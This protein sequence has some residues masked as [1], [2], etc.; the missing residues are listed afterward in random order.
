MSGSSGSQNS[1]VTNKTDV[2]SWLQ[3]A[4][5]SNLGFA[6]DVAAK[7]YEQ[8][9]G[10]QVASI[11]PDQ[12][13][14]YDWVRKNLGAGSNAIGQAAQQITGSNL[15]TT[16]QSL[17]NPYLGA[18]E[19]PALAALAKQGA[20]SQNDLASKAAGA[21]AFG[22]TR[23]G[24]E[25]GVLG[26]ETAAKAGELSAN[27]RSQGWDKAVSTALT[28]AG[29][30]ASLATQQQTAGLA[31]ASA[32]STAGYQQQQNEQA[33]LS[34]ALEDWQNQQNWGQQQLAIREG[35]VTATPYGG[36]TTS[37]QPINKGNP[38]VSALGGALAGA[39]AGSAIPGWGTAAGAL[40]GGVG[41][42]LGSR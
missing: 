11:T 34:A 41:G 25:S 2:P 30:Q 42:Y 5:I 24:V 17:L 13:A 31:G 33:N 15:T 35:A 12:Q 9:T 20:R 38:A 39:A 18:V 4:A 6:Q 10:Q 26:S 7:P 32:L 14:A 16:A 27:I 28:Q 40:I 19:D 21:G 22:G 29:E 23:F 36:T 8:Y 3:D 37:S 1:T